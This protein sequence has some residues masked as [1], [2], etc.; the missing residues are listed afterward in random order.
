MKEGAR[1]EAFPR[2]G[3]RVLPR[4]FWVLTGERNLPQ[5]C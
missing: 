5:G 2:P 1:G 3:P 4:P